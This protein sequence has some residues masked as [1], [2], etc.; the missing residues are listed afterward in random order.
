[1]DTEIFIKALNTHPFY[2]RCIG[3]KKKNKE[4]FA[5]AVKYLSQY[6]VQKE[7]VVLSY[8]DIGVKDTLDYRKKFKNMYKI[9]NG[10]LLFK[11]NMK[12]GK[13]WKLRLY[14]RPSICFDLNAANLVAGSF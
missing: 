1:M 9:N 7:D 14:S 8:A 10:Y 6:G 13:N 5:N 3:Y 12:I 11:R 2:K 4:I